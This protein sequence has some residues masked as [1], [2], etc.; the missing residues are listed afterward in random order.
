MAQF[1]FVPAAVWNV[2]FKSYSVTKQ[3]FSK[4]KIEQNPT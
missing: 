4:Y 1:V 3:E 2:K